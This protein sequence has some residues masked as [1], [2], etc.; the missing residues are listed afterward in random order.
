MFRMTKSLL[1]TVSI[2]VAVAMSPLAIAEGGKR[3]NAVR[4]NNVVCPIGT[5]ED[6]ISCVEDAGFD[7]EQC[8]YTP[9]AAYS[10]IVV[11]ACSE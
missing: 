5:L 11:F 10:A 7:I 9:A 4:T 2:L 8:T 6:H 3:A 1:M